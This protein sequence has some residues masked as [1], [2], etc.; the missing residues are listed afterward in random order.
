[1]ESYGSA[2]NRIHSTRLTMEAIGGK[3][4]EIWEAIKVALKKAWEATKRFFAKL[5]DNATRVRAQ[6]EKLKAAAVQATGT[7]TVQKVTA[8][9]AGARLSTN[10]KV[11]NNWFS[12]VVG[13]LSGGATT[14]EST[15]YVTKL[16]TDVAAKLKSGAEDEKAVGDIVTTYLSNMDAVAGLFKQ[17]GGR[18]VPSANIPGVDNSK[19]AVTLGPVLPGNAVFYAA[20]AKGAG[21]LAE[22]V[23]ASKVGFFQLPVRG[24]VSDEFPIM[25]S[26][27]MSDLADAIISGCDAISKHKG[28]TDKMMAAASELMAAGDAM[29]SGKSEEE[30]AS[31]QAV[32]QALPRL[33][34][35]LGA[36]P[37]QLTSYLLSIS[38]A[39]M[40][41]AK[42]SLV[43]Y[44]G[45]AAPALNAPAATA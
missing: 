26:S 21:S 43:A 35:N 9:G 8:P 33:Q 34:E 23:G 12:V 17:A 44:K 11:E 30:A 22:V 20:T 40:A 29:V 31:A 36:W 39:S 14:I 6:A 4:K 27:A 25:V 45:A 42:A 19:S 15:Q 13:T 16:F 7:P 18:S 38:G 5:F 28:E 10:G 24:E 3:I 2:S 1:M 41:V 37:K 32:L